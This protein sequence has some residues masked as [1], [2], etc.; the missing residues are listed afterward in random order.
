MISQIWTL[1]LPRQENSCNSSYPTRLRNSLLKKPQLFCVN[2]SNSNSTKQDLQL[3][4]SNRTFQ[5]TH[6]WTNL[7][8]LSL[9]D[10]VP[11]EDD[12][13]GLEPCWFVE[14]D[15]QLPDHGGQVL[16]DLLP[17]PLDPHRG[18]VPAGMSIHAAYNLWERAAGK[19]SSSNLYQNN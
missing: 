18:T 3:L 14:L 9:R 12:P 7:S 15:E 10:P 2:A 17:G 5:E 19:D 11:V 16:D 1:L 4:R 6:K 13:G 8:E